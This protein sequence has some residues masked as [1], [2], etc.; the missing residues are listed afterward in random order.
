[1]RIIIEILTNKKETVFAFDF[2]VE[3]PF[4]AFEFLNAKEDDDILNT[5]EKIA[6]CD[7]QVSGDVVDLAQ[8]AIAN[9]VKKGWK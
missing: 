6:S 4:F 2:Y 8:K 7:S 9:Y 1:M 5:L 3:W